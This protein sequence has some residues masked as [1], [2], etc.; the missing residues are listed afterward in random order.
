MAN[1]Y[2]KWYNAETHRLTN[3]VPRMSKQVNAVLVNKG[4]QPGRRL[5]SPPPQFEWVVLDTNVMYDMCMDRAQG[6]VIWGQ[7]CFAPLKRLV[8]LGVR[9]H[10]AHGMMRELDMHLKEKDSSGKPTLKANAAN[11]STRFFHEWESQDKFAIT[12]EENP[13]DV[14]RREMQS[15]EQQ[16]T[17]DELAIIKAT[18]QKEKW[19]RLENDKDNDKMIM[20][21][22][23]QRVSDGETCVLI[24]TDQNMKLRATN[25]NSYDVSSLSYE[26]AVSFLNNTAS[27]TGQVENLNR[28]PH[29]PSDWVERL[30]VRKLAASQKEAA[31]AATKPPEALESPSGPWRGS[32]GATPSRSVGQGSAQGASSST[33]QRG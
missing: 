26:Q 24:T 12:I 17:R 23:S 4:L 20:E 7:Q 15:L 11:A 10:A 16:P 32:Q 22:A 19:A 9:I 13:K 25:L 30:R 27:A 29:K 33:P 5:I 6:R 31:Q 2:H 8:A 21:S 28:R 14:A 18:H 1:I 3:E